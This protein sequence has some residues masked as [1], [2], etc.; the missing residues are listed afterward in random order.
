[1]SVK[2]VSRFPANER[3]YAFVDLNPR[4]QGGL[5]SELLRRISL[6]HGRGSVRNAAVRSGMRPFVPS[7]D[8]EGAIF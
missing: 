3:G 8:R 1:M 2:I 7:R 4:C 5:H 6:P